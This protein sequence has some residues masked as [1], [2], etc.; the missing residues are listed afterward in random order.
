MLQ[1]PLASQEGGWFILVMA[2][3]SGETGRGRAQL[4]VAG[5]VEEQFL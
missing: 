3:T 5:T 4:Y 1:G 2:S